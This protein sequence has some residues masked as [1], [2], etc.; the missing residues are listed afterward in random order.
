MRK[1]KM[2]GAKVCQDPKKVRRPEGIS[3]EIWNFVNGPKGYREYG[4]ETGDFG[5][6][7]TFRIQEYEFKYSSHGFR[8]DGTKDWLSIFKM[9]GGANN[10]RYFEQEGA[11][12]SHDYDSIPS[13]RILNLPLNRQDAIHIIQS[14]YLGKRLRVIARTADECTQYGGRYYL[15]A[16]ED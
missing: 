3:E 14:R 15:F 16:I 13:D 9:S 7:A 12:K 10:L 1:P 2:N 8:C 4:N 11:E 5:I 6:N